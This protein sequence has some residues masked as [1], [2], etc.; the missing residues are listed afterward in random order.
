MTT[1][2]TVLLGLVAAALIAPISAEAQITRVTGSGT[3]QAITVN[4]GAFFPAGEQEFDRNRN[5]ELCEPNSRVDGDV[6][7]ANKE[8]LLFD[9]NEFNGFI[10]G[11]EW[12]FAL[13]DYFELGADISFYQ[14]TAASEYRDFFDETDG[15]VI[16][17]DLKL[18]MMPITAS[19]RFVPTGRNAR[20]QPYIGVGVSFINWHYSEIGEFIDF[21]EGGLVFPAEFEADGTEVAPVVLGGVRFLATD[22]FTLG[23]EVRWVKASGDTGGISQGFV[24]EKI[25][26]GGWTTNFSLGFRF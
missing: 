23:G 24:G 25:D 18:R 10:G 21:D 12:S 15:S 14:K 3:R 5:I 4:L 26:L 1:I 7:C 22:V 13:T 19:V 17:Q 6:L 9:L 11:A 8:S 16:A 20:V 2:R